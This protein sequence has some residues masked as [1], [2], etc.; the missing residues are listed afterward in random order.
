MATKAAPLSTLASD[1]ESADRA[2]QALDRLLAS[3]DARK[4]PAFDP[5]LLA[6]AEGFLAPTQ[7]GGFGESLGMAAGKL[8]SAEEKRIQQEQE[9]AKA[10]FEVEQRRADIARQRK[11]MEGYANIQAPPGA[12]AGAPGGPGGPKGVQ[13]F[14][15]VGMPDYKQFMESQRDQGIPFAQAQENYRKLQIDA[16][17][18]TEGGTTNVATGEFFGVPSADMVNIQIFGYPGTY[19]VAKRAAIQLQQLAADN[20]WDDYGALAKRI[21]EGPA[22][23]PPKPAQPTAPAAPISLGAPREFRSTPAQPSAVTPQPTIT[24]GAGAEQP[25]AARPAGAAAQPSEPAARPDEAPV[26][27]DRWMAQAPVVPG[28]LSQEQLA[29]RAKEEEARASTLGQE[30]AK[31]EAAMPEKEDAAR[32]MNFAAQQVIDLTKKSPNAFGIF[33]RPGLLSSVGGLINEGIRAGTT[34]I[35][36]GDFQA[37]VTKA[38]PGIKQQDLDNLT[39]AAGLLAEIELTYTQLYLKG[40][41]QITEGEREIVRRLGGNVSQSATVLQQKAKLLEM[42]SQ[43]DLNYADGYRKWKE[44]NP[45]ASIMEFERSKE[46]Q[47]MKKSFDQS[48]RDKF[49]GAR[50]GAPASARREADALTG[51]R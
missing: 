31:R 45:R 10:R 50:P 39:Q 44:S 40:Q 18:I 30:S 49:M 21:V 15:G 8:R 2:Q 11:L 35:A 16:L 7:T 33:A 27:R 25:A 34:N 51:R 36:L 24:P 6:L 4:K 20:K 47:D 37:A 12:P 13:L 41:G 1:P 22:A 19:P 32:R 14:P 48:L 3:L 23:A 17:K 5:T 29:A 43:F 28:L 46:V 38:M 26:A 9:D 42:R